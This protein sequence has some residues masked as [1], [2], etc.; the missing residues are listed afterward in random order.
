[1][2]VHCAVVVSTG[3][4][5]VLHPE[6]I[7]IVKFTGGDR[8]TKLHNVR[9]I[10]FCMTQKEGCLMRSQGQLLNQLLAVS[11]TMRCADSLKHSSST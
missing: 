1:M 7:I 4:R 3:T 10:R 9:L 11:A 5:S 8:F 6:P 2:I